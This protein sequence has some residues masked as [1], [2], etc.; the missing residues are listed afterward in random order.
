[1]E[2][3]HRESIRLT[4]IQDIAGCRL[5][6]PDVVTQVTVVQSFKNLFERT[7]IIDRRQ[8]PSHG[9]HAIHVIVSCLDK[10]VEIQVRTSL[11]QLRAEISEKFSDV[12]DSSIKYGGGN[13]DIRKY[14]TESH[15]YIAQAEKVEML[16]EKIQ[17]MEKTMVQTIAG[18]PEELK[19]LLSKS[20]QLSPLDMLRS[21]NAF[22]QELI[23]RIR[24][25]IMA[26]EKL[27]G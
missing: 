8:K 1:V 27:K 2:K 26:V 16:L 18:L 15:L 3:L 20:E 12:I 14:L 22:K 6:V 23:G 11:Q 25:D 19:I 4:Q 24:N 17:T 13:E 9:Y 5:I 21:F 10:T 7:T